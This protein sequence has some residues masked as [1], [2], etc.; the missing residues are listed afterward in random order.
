LEP[1]ADPGRF[2]ELEV[3]EK[4]IL[5]ERGF[6]LRAGE[7]QLTWGLKMYR[8]EDRIQFI[9]RRFSG[10][11]LDKSSTWWSS[12]QN[13]LKLRNQLTH[14]KGTPK[15]SKKSVEDALKAIIDTL[16]VLYKG[17]YHTAYPVAGR[18]LDSTL[19]F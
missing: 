1:P 15:M 17:V 10:K 13:G 2:S 8:L 14:P 18:A 4:L 6:S 12:L 3:L 5:S 9:Y 11:V 16:D 7:Y 19:T